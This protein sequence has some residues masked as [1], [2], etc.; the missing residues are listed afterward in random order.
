MQKANAKQGFPQIP[1]EFDADAILKL[2][3]AKLIQVLKDPSATVFQKAKVCQRLAVLGGKD[4]APALASLLNHPELSNYARFGLEPNP[5]P[6]ADAA[7]RGAL[8]HLDGRLLAGV[9]TSIGVRRDAKSTDALAKLLGHSDDDVAGAAAAALARIGGP[10]SAKMLQQA[11]T[12][13]RPPLQP[14]LARACLI[15]ADGL[16]ASNRTQAMELYKVLS[17]PA[18]PK[19]VRLAAIRAMSGARAA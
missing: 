11:L 10:A 14:V 1:P 6:S 16:A 9:V 3:A 4:A 7:L 13:A 12:T 17:G 19:V 8:A 2:D 5:D 15:C 18:Q